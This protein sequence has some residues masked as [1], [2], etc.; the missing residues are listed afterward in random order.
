MHVGVCKITFRLPQNSSLKGK[1]RVVSSLTTR[2]RNK[3]NVSVA[4]VENNDA[5]QIATIGITCASNSARHVDE[6]LA[7]VTAFIE[8]GRDDI[9]IVGQEQETLSG[10]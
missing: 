3:F 6:V 2:L 10:F 7:N 5:W 1:R 8:A 4:E 9:E